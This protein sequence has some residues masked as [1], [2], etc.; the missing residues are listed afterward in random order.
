[1]PTVLHIE[2]SANTETSQTRAANAEILKHLKP[3]RVITRDLA[4]G[5]P[6][7]THDWAK[8]RLVPED[9]RTQQEKEILQLSDDLV[10]ELQ[11]AHIVLIGMPV[12][13]FG[14]PA[15]LKLWID[16][17]AR[18][19]LTFEYTSDGPRGLLDGKLGIVTYASGGT[20]MG[21]DIDFA[22]PHMRQV[23]KFIGIDDVTWVNTKDPDW[24]S[25]FTAK[26][27]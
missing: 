8:A 27:A 15:A 24:K 23:L 19:K 14:M 18:P 4:Q 2:S 6:Q 5:L 11:E 1:M 3:R 25:Q 16:L 12:Y 20:A 13:N 21:S 7:I 17:I 10:A 22:T 9:E 26:A